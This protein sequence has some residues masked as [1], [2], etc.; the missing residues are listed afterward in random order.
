MLPA[1]LVTGSLPARA[2]WSSLLMAVAYCSLTCTT[3]V[4]CQYSSCAEYLDGDFASLCDVEHTV[5]LRLRHKQYL[6]CAIKI[7]CVLN[8]FVVFEKKFA[9]KYLCTVDVS[10][11]FNICSMV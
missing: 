1:E 2:S 9:A 8:I 6:C 7:I 11:V 4:L 3:F 5:S 10:S